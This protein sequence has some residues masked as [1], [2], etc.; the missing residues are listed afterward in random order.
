MKSVRRFYADI[1]CFKGTWLP[2]ESDK[3]FSLWAKMK[4]GPKIPLLW[5]LL[6]MGLNE[7]YILNSVSKPMNLLESFTKKN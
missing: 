3:D 7:K 4:K 5:F 1:I 6:G 2:S